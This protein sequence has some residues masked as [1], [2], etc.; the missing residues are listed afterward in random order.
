MGD[1]EN[2]DTK[3]ERLA[4]LAEFQTTAILH[5]MKFPRVERISY[6]TCSVHREENED[7]VATVLAVAEV[8][9]LSCSRWSYGFHLMNDFRFCF[10]NVQKIFYL[11][12]LPLNLIET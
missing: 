10:F 11:Q 9:P 4:S 8:G 12:Y 3:A 5:A 6:S 1:S 2:E 7:V